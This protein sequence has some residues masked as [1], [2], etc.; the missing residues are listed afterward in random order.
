MLATYP[1]LKDSN[2]K[3]KSINDINDSIKMLDRAV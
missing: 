3:E 1:G 2:W